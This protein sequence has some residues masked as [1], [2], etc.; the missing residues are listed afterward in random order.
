MI[1][2]ALQ[3]QKGHG[4]EAWFTSSTAYDKQAGRGQIACP[5][6]GSTK[7]EKAL[8]APNVSPRTRR[9]GTDAAR[10]KPASKPVPAATPAA[11]PPEIPREVID[12]MRKVRS[13]VVAKADYVGPRFAEEARKIHHEETPARGIYGEATAEDAKA[14]VEEGIEFYPLPTLP[15]DNN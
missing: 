15:E 1:K 6:C 9:K 8:M 2:Y 7:V 5:R 3:C 14:L 4:F 11:M 12:L 10:V 13:E